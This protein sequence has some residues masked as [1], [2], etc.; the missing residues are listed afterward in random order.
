MSL[1]LRRLLNEHERLQKLFGAHPLVSVR[2]TAGNPP[3]RYIV[4][5][6]V[7][8]L[9]RRP[10]GTLVVRRQ[11]QMEIVLPAEYPRM[12]AACRMLTPVFHPNIDAFTVCTSD[13]HSAQET[14]ADL[15]VRVGQMISFQKHNVK[16]PLNGE[17]AVWCEQNLGRLPVD[18]SDLY[19]PESPPP[20]LPPQSAS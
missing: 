19:P 20:P 16:S 1:R 5:Y 2:P 12:P 4:E 3:D 10:D 15:V 14:L 18:P 7:G 11:H 6:R 9:E 17:A 8:G 13:F